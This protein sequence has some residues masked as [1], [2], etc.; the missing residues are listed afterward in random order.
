MAGGTIRS[1][2]YD[3]LI[4]QLSE[5]IDKNT[6]GKQRVK[7]GDKWKKTKSRE[8]REEKRREE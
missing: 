3:Y 7:R 1:A 2:D 6:K 5:Q 4:G 8:C